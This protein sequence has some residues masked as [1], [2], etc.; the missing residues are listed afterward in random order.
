MKSELATG[1]T[2]VHVLEEGVGALLARGWLTANAGE[3]IDVQYFIFSADAIGLIAA[4]ELL[5]AAERGVKVRLLVDDVLHDGDAKFLLAMNAHPNFEIRVYNPNI[6]IGKSLVHKLAN[7]AKDFRA[8]NQRMHNKTFIVD[9]QVV[10]TGGRNI[11]DEY[12]DLHAS[13]N[14]RDRDIL[15]IGGASHHVTGSFNQ[16]WRH[17]LAVPL[18]KVVNTPVDAPAVWRQL[19]RFACNPKHYWPEMRKRARQVPRRFAELQRAGALRWL[20]NVRFV[21]DDP[22]KNDGKSGLG[23]GGKSTSALISLVRSAKK[24]VIIQTPYLVTTKLGQ[25]LFRETVKRGV[26]LVIV[27]NSLASTDSFPAFAGYRPD[28]A[29]LLKDGVELYETKP[30]PKIRRRLMTLPKNRS[31]PK[32]AIFGLHAKSMV[33]DRETV[34][35]GTFNL[36]PRSANLNTECFVMAKDT[37]LA[38]GVLKLLEAELKPENAW[39]ITPTFN[40]DS[41][42]PFSHKWKAFWAKP[43]P[44]SIL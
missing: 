14:F 36:D 19:H 44:K 9:G 5:L 43:V 31:F 29:L 1:K 10:I 39:R 18:T 35:V 27:T 2:G 20:S 24:E 6:N 41:E 13:Y 21:S 28:R 4:D 17:R 12:F 37:K 32:N 7:A 22:D 26:R 33:I 34:V 23:G 40:P 30:Y 42:A 11:A 25:R 8:V 16:F 38:T 15:L 3:S